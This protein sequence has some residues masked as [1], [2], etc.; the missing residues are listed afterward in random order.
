MKCQQCN[1]NADIKINWL[2]KVS[3][4]KNQPQEAN[5][6]CNCMSKLAEKYKGSQFFETLIISP[7]VNNEDT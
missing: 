3:P 5:L 4:T 6:C 7:L 2:A 1:G